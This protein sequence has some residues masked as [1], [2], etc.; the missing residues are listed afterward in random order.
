MPESMENHIKNNKKIA[1]VNL[2][3]YSDIRDFSSYKEDINFLNKHAIPFKDFASGRNTH[4]LLIEGFAQAI[5]DPEVSVVWF[6]NGGSKFIEFLNDFDWDKIKNSGKI[7]LGFSDFTHFSIL[8][9]QKSIQTYY[10]LSLRKITEYYSES[11]QSEIASTL[12]NLIYA[13]NQADTYKIQ[14]LE[15]SITG[16]HLTVSTFMLSSFNIDLTGKALFIEYHY[17]P[18]ETIDDLIYFVNQLCVLLREKG[19]SPQSFLLGRSMLF[20]EE[21]L[22]DSSFINTHI[23]NV[24]GNYFPEIEIGHLDQFENIIEMK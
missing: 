14:P 3:E 9:N 16:G 4:D 20:A 12:L 24:L 13:G 5:A 23:E 8:A 1:L 11:K 2:A 6:T 10:G 15:K 19:N 22:V 18:G 17:I 7:F 21:G